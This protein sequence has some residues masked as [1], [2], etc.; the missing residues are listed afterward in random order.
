LNVRFLGAHRFLGVL[1]TAALIACGGSTLPGYAAPQGGLSTEADYANA[2][3][4]PYRT[5]TRADFMASAPEGTASQHTDKVGALTHALIKHDP[6][7]GFAG[8]EITSP[9]G[10]RRAE[11]KIQ[12]LYFRAWMDRSRSWWNP[13][14][15]EAPESYVLQ[16]EQIHFAIVEIEA[17][18]MNVEGAALMEKTFK[19]KSSKDIQKQV[20]KELTEVVQE[21]M[22]RVL[23]RS[24]DFDED[25][26]IRYDPKKQNE[27]WQRVQRELAAGK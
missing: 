13:K 24:T 19:G 23:E 7:V 12:N 26:S 4:I 21:G 11:G 25:T 22:D 16:H 5:L 6:G 17:R 14:R 18:K 1:G 20:E 27:W 10:D 9:N 2:D 8:R 3:L 15:G